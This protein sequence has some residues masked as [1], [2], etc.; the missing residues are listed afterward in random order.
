MATLQTTDFI[1]WIFPMESVGSILQSRR[2]ALSPSFSSQCSGLR[3]KKPTP[4][5]NHCHLKAMLTVWR[6]MLCLLDTGWTT[7][8]QLRFIRNI[9]MGV[10][11]RNL[12]MVKWNQTDNQPNQNGQPVYLFYY[13]W[14]ICQWRNEI[15]PTPLPKLSTN[16]FTVFYGKLP[17]NQLVTQQNACGK[18]ATAKVPRTIWHT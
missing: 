11:A 12:S 7:E 2:R 6:P 15:K 1:L 14:F 16:Y 3:K 17:Y 4:G 8:G 10:T 9:K 18:D 13:S 5:A